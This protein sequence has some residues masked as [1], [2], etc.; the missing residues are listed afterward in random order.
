VDVEVKVWQAAAD[1]SRLDELAERHRLTG[2]VRRLRHALSGE[3]P[4]GRR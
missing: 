3:P 2:P 1:D 4:A